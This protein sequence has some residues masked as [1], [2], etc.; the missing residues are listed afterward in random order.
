L[1]ALIKVKVAYVEYETGAISGVVTSV[2]ALTNPRMEITSP[3]ANILS[4]TA[5]APGSTIITLDRPALDYSN[6]LVIAGHSSAPLNGGHISYTVLSP[7]R[8]RVAI[9]YSAG[10][11]GTLARR[12][13]VYDQLISLSDTPTSGDPNR[14]SISTKT[15]TGTKSQFDLAFDWQGGIK[16]IGVERAIQ[17]G[18]IY[19]IGKQTYDD[20]IWRIL[21]V[22]P[23]IE[24]GTVQLKGILWTQK[25]HEDNGIVVLA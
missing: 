16:V 3:F 5:G 18:D 22:Q 4:T 10:T 23:D 15:P 6:E 14:I 21:E 13:E 2:Q 8:I 9:P 24:K 17:A 11:S 25:I 1:G 19:A 12:R 20:K 7:S